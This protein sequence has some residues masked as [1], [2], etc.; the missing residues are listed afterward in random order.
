VNNKFHRNVV[1]K[2]YSDVIPLGDN[3]FLFTH[4]MLNP[5]YF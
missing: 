3:D 2:Q 1:F 5:Y 4:W